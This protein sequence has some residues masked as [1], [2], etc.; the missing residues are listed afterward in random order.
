[1][2]NVDT[3]DNGWPFVMTNFSDMLDVYRARTHRQL[4]TKVHVRH[5][6]VSKHPL[7]FDPNVLERW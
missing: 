6:Q 5:A 4:Q 7:Q 2:R 1:M 3:I